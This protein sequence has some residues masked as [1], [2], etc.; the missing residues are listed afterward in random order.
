MQNFLKK[1]GKWILYSIFSVVTLLLILLLVIRMNSSGNEE[2][3]LDAQGNISPHSI[4]Y[5]EDL[6]VNGVA[7][8][9]TVRG[10][11]V[12]NPILLLVH[13]GPGSPFLPSAMRASG[14]LLEDLFTVCV[15]EQRGSGKTY[16][17]DLPDSVVT[18]DHIVDDGLDIVRYLKKKLNKNKVYIEGYS[19]GTTVSAFMVQ[20]QPDLFHAYI[21]V[22]QMA[23][24][25]LSEELSWNFAMNEAKSHQDTFSI[26]QLNYIGCP[27][28]D[29]KSNGELV[30]ACNIE[31]RIVRKYNPS[32]ITV[33]DLEMLKTILLDNGQTFKDKYNMFFGDSELRWHGYYLLWPTCYH[34]NLMRDVP[35]L[36][37]PVFMIQ[38][39]NDHHTETSVAKTYFDSLVAPKKRW[40]V[41][42]EATHSVAYEYPMKY[43]SIYEEEILNKTMANTN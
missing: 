22:G 19:W 4:A 32:R 35:E 18:L 31:R 13:G 38:G 25:P 30:E 6:L 11:D 28:Y 8:R 40:L 7:Q 26:N 12:N 39:E 15:W 2:P 41:I 27:P 42:E 20:K 43:R 33:S 34:T 17:G 5:H 24:Q 16:D 10:E 29:S 9:I 36:K 14:V 23:N 1:I 37:V 21:G 3:I